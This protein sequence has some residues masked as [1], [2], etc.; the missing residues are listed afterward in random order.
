M[1]GARVSRGWWPSWERRGSQ[2]TATDAGVVADEGSTRGPTT[3]AVSTLPVPVLRLAALLIAAAGGL[4]F[5][6]QVRYVYPYRPQLER[7][8]VSVPPAHAGLANLKIAFLTDSHVGPIIS[9]AHLARATALLAAERPDL[10]L[11]GGDY[12]SEAPRYAAEAAD[13]LGTLADSTPLGAFAVLGNHDLA[14]GA[15]AVTA[16]LEAVGIRVLRNAAAEV[17]T[18]SGPLWIAGI[19]EAILG[20]ADPAAAFARV[21]SG[22]AVLALWHEPDFAEQAAA[23]GAF[24]QLSGHSHGGQVRLPWLGPLVLPM[25]GRRFAAGFNDAAG[26]PVY[27]SRG[28]GVYRPPIRFR[29]PAEVTLVTLVAPASRSMATDGR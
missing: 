16:A 1:I 25:G 18:D 29:C 15:E 17:M 24:A 8:Q 5:F 7:I 9:P 6:R 12:I 14:C 2:R 28:A 3:M 21:P 4:L 23:L 11:L 22:A 13:V 27:T 10:L 19:D 26:M 20:A